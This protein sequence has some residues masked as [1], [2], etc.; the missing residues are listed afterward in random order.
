L[1]PVSSARAFLARTNKESAAGWKLPSDLYLAAW[2]LMSLAYTYSGFCKLMS[3][4]WVD[5]S[6]LSRVLANPLARDTMPRTVLLGF[7]PWLLQAGTWLALALELTFAPLALFKKI[8]PI[9]W[10]AMVGM[11]LSLMV[12]INFADL[13]AGMLVLHLFT[14]DPDWVRAP[15]P[16]GETVFFDGYCGLCH[17]LVRFILREDQSAQPFVFAP[18]QGDLVRRTVPDDIRSSLPDS[19]AVTDEKNRILVRSEAVIYVA[20]RLGGLWFIGATLLSVVPR[21]VRD[22]GYDL[23]ASM[24][25]KIMGTTQQ[26]CPLVP[27]PLRRRFRY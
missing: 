2:I 14:F 17:G 20:K 25:K 16:A 22:F 27:E 11:H 4:S 12:L 5:G 18:L 24:R 1:I 6:A 13:T 8:R 23:V 7:P 9:I 15:R 19:V 3:P 21:R 26:T 10:L